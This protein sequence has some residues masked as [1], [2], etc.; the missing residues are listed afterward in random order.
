MENQSRI[1]RN[2]NRA[3]PGN[4]S[5]QEATICISTFEN[6]EFAMKN[7]AGRALSQS[8]YLSNARP[9]P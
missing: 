6:S 2:L 5:Q 7:R 1:C 9:A 3:E 8:D 4:I